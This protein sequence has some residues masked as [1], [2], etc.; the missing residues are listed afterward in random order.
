MMNVVIMYDR[1]ERSA[2][3]VG[4][5]TKRGITCRFVFVRLSAHSA[6]RDIILFSNPRYST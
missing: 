3:F 5:K 1:A 6:Q 2:V 4:A